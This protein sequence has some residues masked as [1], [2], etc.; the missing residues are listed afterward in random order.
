MFLLLLL[1]RKGEPAE[2]M[3]YMSRMHNSLHINS[4]LVVLQ[5]III[6]KWILIYYKNNY[7]CTKFL[8]R[9]IVFASDQ[10]SNLVA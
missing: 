3:S 1:L 9:F 4:I 2:L 8:N 5:Y 7:P 10:G 6:C